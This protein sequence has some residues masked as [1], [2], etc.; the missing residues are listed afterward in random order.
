[1]ILRGQLTEESDPALE[2][3]YGFSRITFSEAG[4]F[5]FVYLLRQNLAGR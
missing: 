5:T 3:V 1:M 4:V 2:A